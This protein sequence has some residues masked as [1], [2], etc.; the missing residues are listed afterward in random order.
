MLCLPL[1]RSLGSQTNKTG[2][3][4]E[5]GVLVRL[6]SAYTDADKSTLDISLKYNIGITLS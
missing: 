6:T 2:V 4:A 1:K 5:I 3:V